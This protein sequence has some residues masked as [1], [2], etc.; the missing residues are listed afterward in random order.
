M[1]ALVFTKSLTGFKGPVL[2]LKTKFKRVILFLYNI[3]GKITD[4]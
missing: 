4:C 1:L 3:E 2:V